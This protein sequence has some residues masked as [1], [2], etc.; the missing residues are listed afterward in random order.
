MQ[1]VI[2]SNSI[3]NSIWLSIKAVF[4]NT[5]VIATWGLESC[6]CRQISPRFGHINGYFEWQKPGEKDIGC[7]RLHSTL[8]FCIVIYSYLC[9]FIYSASTFAIYTYLIR[10][11]IVWS[12][13]WWFHICLFF[14]GKLYEYVEFLKYNPIPVDI[15]DLNHHTKNLLWI[16]ALR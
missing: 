16:L 1:Q 10:S 15:A 9:M 14:S 2:S 12:Y 8:S 6:V 11:T 4:L 5:N 13:R 7:P 3:R